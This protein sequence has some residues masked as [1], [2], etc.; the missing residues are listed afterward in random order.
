MT[1]I[2]KEIC[3]IIKKRAG[4]RFKKEGILLAESLSFEYHES[5]IFIC[6]KVTEFSKKGYQVHAYCYWNQYDECYAF[7]LSSNEISEKQ[8]TTACNIQDIIGC[9]D[10]LETSYEE[11]LDFMH[12]CQTAIEQG[13]LRKCELPEDVKTQ[14][15][16][17]I[18]FEEDVENKGLQ[19]LL[20][21]LSFFGQEAYEFAEQHNR[22]VYISEHHSEKSVIK[23]QRRIGWEQIRGRLVGEYTVNAEMGKLSVAL[24]GRDEQEARTGLIVLLRRFKGLSE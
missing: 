1:S 2:K 12:I 8:V 24:F 11:Q 3:K 9:M 10:N 19:E 18:E 14:V 5:P 20:D 4:A 15:I 23:K 17:E 13:L 22:L 21:D 7:A 16:R 6:E